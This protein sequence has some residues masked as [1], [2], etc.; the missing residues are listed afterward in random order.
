MKKVICFCLSTFLLMSCTARSKLNYVAYYNGCYYDEIDD[1][2]PTGSELREKQDAWVGWSDEVPEK[3]ENNSKIILYNNDSEARFIKYVTP[4]LDETHILH[5][6]TDELPKCWSNDKVEKIVIEMNQHSI[7]DITLEGDNLT[8][9]LDFLNECFTNPEN[10]VK[11]KDTE[12]TAFINV[13]FKDYPANYYVGQIGKMK[14]GSL[15]FFSS[16]IPDVEDRSFYLVVPELLSSDIL[17][18]MNRH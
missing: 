6:R 12:L 10:F 1:W 4:N 13:H 9:F 7:A 17:K 18:Q 3:P 2:V 15:V 14:S 11:E 5:K 8:K 16:N